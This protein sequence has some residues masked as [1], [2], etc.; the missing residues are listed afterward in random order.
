MHLDAYWTWSDLEVTPV[1]FYPDRKNY[2]ENELSK[3][4]QREN[5]KTKHW[6]T[7]VITGGK[8]DVQHGWLC[9]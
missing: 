5:T 4:I 3:N 7:Q 1:F 9:E 6:V 8:A 2:Y